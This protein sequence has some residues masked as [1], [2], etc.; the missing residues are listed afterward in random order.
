MIVFSHLSWDF[1]G[2][3]YDKWFSIESLNILWDLG[4]YLN[5]LFSRPLLILLAFLLLIEVGNP[6]FLTR[7]FLTPRYY[8]ATA[9]GAL[10]PFHRLFLSALPVVSKDT[11]VRWPWYCWVVDKVLT[12]GGL[13]CSC[14][15]PP[16]LWWE[17]VFP[18]IISS[19]LGMVGERHYW[20]FFLKTHFYILYRWF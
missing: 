5:L 14:G 16:Q 11:A 13:N 19:D 20:I 1:P 8:M 18:A 15:S 3:W 2:F 10:Y 6:D 4:F 12:P 17:A 9:G 7:S